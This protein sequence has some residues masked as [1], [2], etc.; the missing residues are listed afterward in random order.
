MQA[1][2][3]ISG[4]VNFAV[5]IVISFFVFTKKRNYSNIIFSILTFSTALWS[6]G[7]WRW[8]S[9]YDTQQSA[10]F[11]LK[12]LTLGSIW[13]PILFTHWISSLFIRVI[14]KKVN[15]LILVIAYILGI[16]FSV[17]NFSSNLM[18]SG[19]SRKLDF[20]FGQT[21]DHFI[22]IILFLYILH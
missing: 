22:F 7:Y 2:F 10:I 18:V 4:L 3:A 20:I 21:R 12:F 5:S 15:K 1:L 11:W 19:V 8:L 14:I 9:I 13:I 17:I 16:F 6:F